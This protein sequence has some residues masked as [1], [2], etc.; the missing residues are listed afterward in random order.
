MDDHERVRS[1]EPL[2]RTH[3]GPLGQVYRVLGRPRVHL[4]G[5]EDACSSLAERVRSSPTLEAISETRAALG[6][7]ERSGWSSFG[8]RLR[9]AIEA[10]ESADRVAQ[11]PQ[12]IGSKVRVEIVDAAQVILHHIRCDPDEMFRI[13]L[14]TFEDLICHCLEA[15]GLEVRRT[16]PVN[17]GDGGIDIVFWP[18]AGSLPYLGAAQVK[19]HRTPSK[20]VG[21]AVVRDFTG[22]MTAHRFSVG[23]V[24]TNTSFTPTAK[25]FAAKRAEILRLRDIRDVK[26]WVRGQFSDPEELRELPSEIEVCPGFRIQVLPPSKRT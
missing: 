23:L 13:S 22:A 8:G 15:M 10:A 6:A 26:R 20:K 2:G 12:S 17:R 19:H 14:G 25:W 24:V 7:L 18:P 9:R 21:V 3:D 11:P 1:Y 16:G 4:G 5:L